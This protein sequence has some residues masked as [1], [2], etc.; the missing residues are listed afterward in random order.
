MDYIYVFTFL[1]SLPLIWNI[2][3]S[4]HFETLFQSGKVWQI[5]AAYIIVTIII[6]H[7]FASAISEFV[8]NIYALF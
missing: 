5:K 2:L 4:L 8:N 7:L 6:S 1:L 3:F